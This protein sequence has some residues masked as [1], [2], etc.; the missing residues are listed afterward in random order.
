MNGEGLSCAIAD[1]FHASLLMEEPGQGPFGRESGV[2]QRRQRNRRFQVLKGY[3]TGT[4]K[5]RISRCR[6]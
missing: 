6:Q 2:G 4:R 5:A 3:R 1:P